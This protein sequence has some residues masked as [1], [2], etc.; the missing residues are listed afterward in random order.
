V[1]DATQAGVGD[2]VEV[3]VS[4]GTLATRVDEIRADGTEDLLQ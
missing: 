1:H 3:M 2:R 4:R